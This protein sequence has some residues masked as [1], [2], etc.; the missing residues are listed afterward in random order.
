MGG[1]PRRA[2]RREWAGPGRP[3]DPREEG[4]GAGVPLS[5]ASAMAS[6]EA[7]V[8]H[9][10]TPGGRTQRWRERVG[11]SQPM[12]EHLARAGSANNPFVRGM[13][14]LDESV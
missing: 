3:F 7:A 14:A 2:K 12:Y 10:G 9:E 1:A 5:A 13:R 11:S 8:L 4:R 6:L